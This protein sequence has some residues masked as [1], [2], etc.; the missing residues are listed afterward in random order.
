MSFTR[1]P[2][3]RQFNMANGQFDGGGNAYL[4]SGLRCHAH[5]VSTAGARQS[6][7]ISP[8]TACRCSVMNQLSSVHRQ[9]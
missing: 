5:I 7:S 2:I 3:T 4:A 6:R 9:A 1:K 8:F